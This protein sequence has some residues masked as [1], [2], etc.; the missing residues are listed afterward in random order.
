LTNG[1]P[2]TFAQASC[3]FFPRRLRFVRDNE[4]LLFMLHDKYFS[5]VSHA[6]AADVDLASGV[7]QLDDEKNRE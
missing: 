7:F 1:D 4:S 2:L 3:P 6:E 5:A